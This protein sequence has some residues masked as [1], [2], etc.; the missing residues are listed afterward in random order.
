MTA[1]AKITPLATVSADETLMEHPGVKR[2]QELF[3]TALPFKRFEQQVA[4]EVDSR[5]ERIFQEVN[6]LT[7]EVY[8]A[9]YQ[10]KTRLLRMLQEEVQAMF[11]EILTKED[12]WRMPTLAEAG[13]QIPGIV[14]QQMEAEAAQALAH[15]EASVPSSPEP[16]PAPAAVANPP[17]ETPTRKTV[18]EPAPSGVFEGAIRLKVNAQG[19]VRQSLQFIHDLGQLPQLT[20]LRLMGG[21]QEE[22]DI[23]VSLRAPV[24]LGETIGQ[25]QNVARVTAGTDSKGQHQLTVWLKA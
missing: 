17:R 2:T 15:V 18:T 14:K 9:V 3:T 13:M 22:L 21:Q 20:V 24:A 4:L 11:A 1:Y 25:M 16:A 8:A 12:A 5:A 23:W 19:R 6:A 10:A 7:T